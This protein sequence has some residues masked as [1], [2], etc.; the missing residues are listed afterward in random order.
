MAQEAVDVARADVLALA[1]ARIKLLEH[2]T[3]NFAGFHW[4]C[5]RHHVAVGMRLDA[6]ALLEQCQMP[7]VFA[8]KAIQVAVVLKRHDQTCLLRPG[9]FTQ[10]RRRWPTHACQ[11]GGLRMNA[12]SRILKPYPTTL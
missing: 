2:V 10:P 8:E 5:Q 9:Y 3:R 1:D 6:K 12:G 4:A 7:V 11:L